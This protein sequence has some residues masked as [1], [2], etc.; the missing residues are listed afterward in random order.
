MKN[1]EILVQGLV[2]LMLYVKSQTITQYVIVQKGTPE[3]LSKFVDLYLQLVSIKLSK[4]IH[5]IT[6]AHFL[7]PKLADPCIP[8]P[9]G[10]NAA[11]NNGI[12]T[13]LSEYQG[14]PY[15]ECRPECVLNTDCPRDKACINQKCKDPCP[16]I[17]GQNAECII[18][19]HYPSCNCISG[20][21][22]DPFVV[23]TKIQ[24]EYEKLLT[25]RYL[26]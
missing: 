18:F 10:S 17:C 6:H 8:N 2:E 21:S 3:I 15:R 4:R 13:C 7:A 20:Y 1:V 19:N 14:D 11:C 12:C 5:F 25:I 26:I 9:C 24:S 16:G 23:C 22:G